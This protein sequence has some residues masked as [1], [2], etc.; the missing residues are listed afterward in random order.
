LYKILRAGMDRFT[1]RSMI[2]AH[3]RFTVPAPSMPPSRADSD[4]STPSRSTHDAVSAVLAAFQAHDLDGLPALL[5]PD[6]VLRDSSDAVV[7][8]PAAIV[9]AIRPMLVA[10]PDLEVEVVSLF[11]SGNRAVAELVRTGTH[12]GPLRGPEMEIPPTGRTVRM[13][14]AILFRVQ[15]RRVSE[16]RAYVDRL[17]ILRELEIHS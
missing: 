5:T 10:F 17:H 3:V 6:A 7:E 13:P 14:E 2:R 15:D 4:R 16:L 9:E 1:V 8:G 12:T 11:T